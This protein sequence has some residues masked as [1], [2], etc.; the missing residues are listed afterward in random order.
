MTRNIPLFIAFRLLFNARFYY[1]V[2]AVIQIDYGLTMAQFAILNAVWA[3]SIVLLEVPSGALADRIGRKR[4][5]VGASVLMVAEM[6]VIAFVPI[7]NN[8]LVFWAWV[9]NRI[10]SGAAEAA[11]SGADEALAYDSIPP[12]DQK[13]RWPKVLSRLMSL[14]SI[15]FV[16]AML[17]GSAV[18]DPELVNRILEFFGSGWQVGKETVLR[19]PIYLTLFT[20]CGAVVVSSLMKEPPLETECGGESSMW[21]GILSAGRWILGAPLV[22]GIILAALVHDSVARLFLTTASEYYRLIDIPVVWFGVI[23]AGFSA[24]G[25]FTPRIAE[26]LVEHRGMRSN[27]LI[28]SALIF[29][30]LIG[31]TFAIPIWGVAI[32]IFFSIGFSFLNFF[33]S[34]YLNAEVSSRQRATVLSFR[35]LAL[36]LGFGGISLIY[37]GILRY[38]G[39]TPEGDAGNAVFR[40]SLYWLP[41]I[42]LILFAVLVIYDRKKLRPFQRE[43][44]PPSA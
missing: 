13:T 37:G 22:G 28:V 20:A 17:T 29:S 10:L 19:F 33:T 25:I 36:N 11:A 24:L 40:E 2:F 30:G 9:L 3:V 41:G 23:G 38:L 32:V 26:W 4:M 5:V 42:F 7:G 15:A 1:P 43:N 44:R 39:R 16:F 35:G 31:I 12:E 34:H 14:S 27:Y 6:A 18:Y 8:S 21:S